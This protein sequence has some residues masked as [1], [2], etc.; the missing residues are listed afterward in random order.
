M[1]CPRCG[2]EQINNETRFCS[3]CGFLMTGV[4]EL[5]AH[6]GLIPE[7]YVQGRAGKNSPKKRGIR[8]GAMLFLSGILIVPLLGIII[9]G[10]LNFEGYIVGIAALLTFLGGILRMLFAL[11]FESPD[12]TDKTLE[13]NMFETSQRFLNRQKDQN[14]LPP[15]QSLPTSAYVP[16]VAGNW[17]DTN[18]LEV[19]SVTEETTKLLERE[20]R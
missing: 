12:P 5:I 1:F 18:D 16:P 11:L 9:V 15:A 13:E 20:T 19:S 6:E 7:K 2:Q 17:R 4:S 10:I 8:Q 14:T 3:R